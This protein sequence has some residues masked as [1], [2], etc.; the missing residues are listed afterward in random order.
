MEREANFFSSIRTTMSMA[1]SVKRYIKSFASDAGQSRTS[2]NSSPS[3]SSSFVT[4]CHFWLA[5]NS[6]WAAF[7]LAACVTVAMRL[8]LDKSWPLIASVIFLSALL[9]L[10][11]LRKSKLSLKTLLILLLGLASSGLLLWPYL[12]RGAFVGV[13]GDTFLYSAFGQY[14][15]DHHRGFEYGLSPIDQY[16]TGMSES[17]FGTA[18]VLGFFSV[19]FHSS[20][21]AVLPIYVLIVLANIFS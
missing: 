2:S 13:T 9:A 12:T 11:K 19:L 18:S 17:R 1:T 6:I 20:V 7:V 14:L 5:A 21:A 4:S 15:A 8:R 10:R 3:F 16:A